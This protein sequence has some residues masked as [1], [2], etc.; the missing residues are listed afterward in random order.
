MEQLKAIIVEDEQ[1]N[2]DVLKHFLSSYCK[3]ISLRG[4]AEDVQSALALISQHEIDLI[5]LDIM[6]AKGTGFDLLD[7]IKNKEIQVIF[8]TA[9]NNYAINAFKYSAVDYLLKPLQIEELIA[10][11]EKAE[12]R[13]KQ[14]AM[15]NQI[16][17]LM[18]K[19]HPE[20]SSN[21]DEFI[22]IPTVEKIEF[23]EIKNINHIEADG[24]YTSFYLNDEKPVVSSKN[25]GE[26]DKMLAD[27]NSFFRVHHK[28]IVNLRFVK[29]ISKSDGVYCEMESGKLIPIS[30]RRKDDL[31]KR[32]KLK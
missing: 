11:V 23:I 12:Q 8:I 22:A 31:F 4:V 9:Y 27:N 14:G 19:L 32:L 5:F 20:K 1:D 21:K 7:N 15:K 17:I 25:L 2:V 28:Y 13:I 18:N 10:S 30:R 16:E 6:L 26:Y 29:S 3:Q 24:T